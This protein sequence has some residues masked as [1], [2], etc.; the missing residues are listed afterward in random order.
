M[1]NCHWSSPC[2]RMNSAATATVNL[3]HRLKGVQDADQEW[4]IWENKA[5]QG[6]RQLDVFR[7]RFYELNFLY[8]LTS[9][10]TLKLLMETPAP[11]TSN[12]LLPKCVLD[13]M[14]PPSLKTHIY[15]PPSVQFNRSFVSDSLWPHGLQHTRPPYPSLSSRVSSDSRPLSWWCRPTISSFVP[16]FSFCRK[17]FP[18]SGSFPMSRL[19]ASGGQVLELQHQSFQWMFRVDFL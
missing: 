12:N 2:T 7:I 19:F 3:Q 13:S 5:E 17:S 8:L 15:T 6:F 1:K 16:A 18:A 10:K 14:C 4:G 11:V 9:R